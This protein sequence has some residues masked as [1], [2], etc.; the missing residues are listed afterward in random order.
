MAGAGTYEIARLDF[1]VLRAEDVVRKSVV[2]VTEPSLYTG[3]SPRPGGANDLRLG[4]TSGWNR[5]LTCLQDSKACLGHT[6][7]INLAEPQY[8]C[9]YVDVVVKVLRCVCFFCSRLLLDEPAGGRGKVVLAA[10]AGR[11]KLRRKCPHCGGPQPVYAKEDGAVVRTW[12]PDTEFASD[13]ERGFAT[14]DF[15][16][17][18]AY[19]ILRHVTARDLAGMG[20]SPEA[21][22]EDMILTKLLVPSTVVRPSVAVSDSSRSRGQDDLTVHII[23]DM[24][25]ARH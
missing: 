6:G 15:R 14:A 5:C 12:P 3:A 17:G 2:E 1:S 25:E 10:V 20:M 19:N 22:P 7:H 13:D 24:I 4:T 23:D 9:S 8:H 21:R 16:A 11:A 18:E